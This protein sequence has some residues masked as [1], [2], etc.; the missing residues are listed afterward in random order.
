MTRLLLASVA[1]TLALTGCSRPRQGDLMAVAEHHPHRHQGECH[2]WIHS[3]K[4][5]FRYCASPALEV[6]LDIE[7]VFKEKPKDG[8]VTMAALTERGEKVYTEICAACHQGNGQGVAGAYPPLA[9][10][11]EFYGT[12][13]NMAGI[14]VNGL[15]GEIVVQ[16]ATY[17]GA[18]P[19]QGQLSDY[20]VA[21]VATYVRNTWGNADGM[22]TPEN[23]K[24]A[25]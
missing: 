2:S 3:F 14:I 20:E 19:A 22:V 25:R 23:V 13:E 5:G 17:N 9:G 6:E 18:M 1:F 21:A 11:G 24:A 15:S 8:P 16:G 4:T 7:P 12:P 10:S